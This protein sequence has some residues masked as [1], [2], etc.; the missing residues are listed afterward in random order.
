MKPRDDE[1]M[2]IG[3]EDQRHAE[4]R[5]KIAD[6][7]ALLALGR[8]YGGHETEAELLRDHRTRDL[9]CRDRQTRSEAQY[10]ANQELLPERDENRTG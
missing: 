5:E 10:H 6:D 4:Q 3:S 9:Q 7:Q 1:M 2:Q 8:V